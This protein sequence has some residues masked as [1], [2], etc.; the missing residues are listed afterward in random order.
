MSDGC[1][2]L[3]IFDGL[4]LLG[5]GA[6]D[7]A[8]ATPFERLA[9]AVRAARPA[10]AVQLAFLEFMTP[11]LAEAGH[12]LARDGCR[13][14]VVLPL[15]LGTGGHVRRDVPNQIEELRRACPQVTWQLTAAVGDDDRLIETLAAIA[16]DHVD[17]HAHL[18]A[19]GDTDGS[20]MHPGLGRPASSL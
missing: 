5:H 8:W 14:I 6:R 19:S 3:A 18:A 11:G 4:I 2:S 15:F 7:P 20:R 10:V 12:R 13:R 17:A 16:V 9:E 1:S